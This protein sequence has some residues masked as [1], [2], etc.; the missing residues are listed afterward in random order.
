MRFPH[1]PRALHALRTFPALLLFRILCLLPVSRTAAAQAQQPHTLRAGAAST[2]ITLRE[3][4][5]VHDPLAAKALV[6]QADAQPVVL[7]TL[8]VVAIG[9]IGRIGDDFLPN[10]RA[11][12]EKECGIPPERVF[13]NASHCHGIPA[14][15]TPEL[16]F[17]TVRKAWQGMVPVRVGSGSVLED[18]ISENRRLRLRDGSEADMRRAYALPPDSEVLAIGPIDPMVALVRIDRMDGTPL[19]ALYQF[20][21]HPILNPPS[22]G[23]SADFPGFASRVIEAGLGHGAV[24]LFLQGCG[25]DINPVRYKSVQELPQAETLGN[26]LGVRVMGA[27]KELKTGGDNRLRV[28]SERVVLPRGRDLAARIAAV[29]AERA[30][31]V[32]GLKGTDLDFRSFLP[33]YL[34]ERLAPESPSFHVQGYLHEKSLGQDARRLLDG[35]NHRHVEAYLGNVRIMEQ[36]TRLNAN[37]ALLRKHALEIEAAG[38]RPL[39]AE[40]GG[41]RIGDFR[42]ITF[43]G[44]LTVEV[45]LELKRKAGPGGLACVSGYTNGYLYYL[46]TELQRRNRGVAQEDCDCVVAPEWRAVFEARA[47]SVLK[48]L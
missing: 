39:E 36:L 14:P 6:L 21:C 13:V 2:D 15:E 43:P 46:P 22:L 25:G 30:R 11:R 9:G 4:I 20:A 17:Q 48:K 28:L 29:E 44:E 3:G 23:N 26:L 35:D 5:R 7:L 33:L 16:A 32:Q 31:L 47:L 1:K 42:W 10:L 40:L 24:A 38:S 37:L 8:D 19:A 18:R 12:L 41:L 34:Q 27:L 45:G